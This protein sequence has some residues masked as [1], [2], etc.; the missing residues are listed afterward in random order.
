MKAYKSYHSYLIES[1]KDSKEAAVYLD[2]AF[3]EGSPEEIVLALKNVAEARKDL[4]DSS[5]ETKADWE[6]CYQLLS[7]AQMPSFPTLVNLL[8]NLGLKLSV[9][10][11][12]EQVA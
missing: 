1:L 7:K 2:V 12:H 3:E 5:D 6:S 4:E 9:M 11:E 8:G 10:A